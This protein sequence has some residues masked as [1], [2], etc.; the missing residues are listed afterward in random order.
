M[1]LPSYERLVRG[2]C[3]KGVEEHDGRKNTDKKI[4]GYARV[5][6]YEQNEDRQVIA[7]KEMGVPEKQIYIDKQSGN[8]YRWDL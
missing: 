2:S 5:S 7:L 4:L 1:A 3:E 6:S 8:D